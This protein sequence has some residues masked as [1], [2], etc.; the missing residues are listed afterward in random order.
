MRR[1]LFH[2]FDQFDPLFELAD[3]IEE[4]IDPLPVGSTQSGV[5]PTG[6]GAD[7]VEDA[8]SG[9]KAFSPCGHGLPSWAH[10]EEALEELPWIRLLG[11]RRAGR[12]PGNV[13]GIG[14]GVA[15]VA[16]TG[17]TPPFA[18]EFERS[19]AGSAAEMASRDLVD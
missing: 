10:L 17:L 3:G 19:E 11:I 5:Q 14:A 12:S 9:S 8:P 4:L 15:G 16:I 7:V 2:L 1:V 13:G 18:T 6:I